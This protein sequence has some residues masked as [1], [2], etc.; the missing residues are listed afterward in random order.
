M[1]RLFAKR[2]R[3]LR[4]IVVDTNT[5]LAKGKL[6]VLD[7]GCGDGYWLRRLATL[8]D[9]D[10]EMVGVDYNPL[11]AER[12]RQAAPQAEI[13][14]ASLF[15][16]ELGAPYDLILLSQVIEHIEE[17]EALLRKLRGLLT[18]DGSFV[19]GTPC[20]GS[21]LQ[22]R[23]LRR[24]GADT[25]HVHFYTERALR[26]KL[27][28]QGFRIVATLREPFFPGSYRA[29]Y[30]LMV[31]RWGFHLLELLTVLLPWGA[32]DVYFACRPAPMDRR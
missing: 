10:L 14:V 8:D 30:Q 9:L 5:R 26:A 13:H 2:W 15:D 11:R 22:R 6:R 3:F 4:R 12:A 29:F 7:A 28:R 25:D 31:R 32:S 24:H 19:L 21:W 1:R 23:W 20:E 16:F 18:T 27:A 17:D